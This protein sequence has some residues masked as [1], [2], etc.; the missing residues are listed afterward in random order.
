[1]EHTEQQRQSFREEFKRRRR[2]QIFVAIP[3]VGALLA[4][5]S[6]SGS[7]KAPTVMGLPAEMVAGGF[8]VLMIGALA[9]SLFNWRCPACN[10]YLGKS[11][12]P[13]FCAKC[14]V[15]LGEIS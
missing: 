6:A 14:G 10:G 15:S 8:L 7:S 2:R 5:M 1:V 11:I 12:S 9:F 13:R 3:V 4:M